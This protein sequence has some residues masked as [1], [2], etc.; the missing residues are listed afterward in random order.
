M[1]SIAFLNTSV[2]TAFFDSVRSLLTMSA[3][4]FFGAKSPTQSENSTSEASSFSVGTSGSDA[5]R[6]DEKQASARSL[7]ALIWLLA[8]AIEEARACELLPSSAVS[9]G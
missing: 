5:A 8:A 9:A 7:P 1:L 3:D 6:F 4:V 2:S